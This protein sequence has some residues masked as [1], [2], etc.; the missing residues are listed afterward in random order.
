MA[1]LE[2]R[3]VKYSEK[4]ISVYHYTSFYSIQNNSIPG[5]TKYNVRLQ[6]LDEFKS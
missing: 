1:K 2:K 3:G 6:K 4:N 5:R